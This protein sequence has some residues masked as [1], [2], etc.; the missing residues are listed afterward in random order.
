MIAPAAGCSL[1]LIGNCLHLEEWSVLQVL[2]IPHGK[3]QSL[4]I[5]ILSVLSF[6]KSKVIAKK[7]A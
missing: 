2:T 5:K 1:I 3:F 7:M 6:L 4:V